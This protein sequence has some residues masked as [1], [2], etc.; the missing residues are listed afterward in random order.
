MST[1]VRDQLSNYELNRFDQLWI[2]SSSQFDARFFTKRDF[3]AFTLFAKNG[4]GL[5]LLSDAAREDTMPLIQP[6]TRAHRICDVRGQ[7]DCSEVVPG[8][9][10][11]VLR[12]P[13]DFAAG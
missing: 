10:A 13:S 6:P 9:S 12:W 4:K 8:K 2:F 11:R 3:D 1:F 7:R 5:Y